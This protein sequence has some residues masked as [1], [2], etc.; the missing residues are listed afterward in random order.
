MGYHS[1]LVLGYLK[2]GSTYK[3]ERKE[4]GRSDVDEKTLLEIEMSISFESKT[5][6]EG[7]ERENAHRHFPARPGKA[8]ATT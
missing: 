7:R 1:R 2:R 3:G 8:L 4:E 6:K 5:K